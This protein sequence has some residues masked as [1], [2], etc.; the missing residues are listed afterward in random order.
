MRNRTKILF[1]L[2]VVVLVV[3]L[4]FYCYA[5]FFMWAYSRANRTPAREDFYL[6]D[7]EELHI[8]FK[9]NWTSEYSVL[10]KLK[11]KTT[12]KLESLVGAEPFSIDCRIFRDD[13]K[14][15][16]QEIASDVLNNNERPHIAPGDE[17]TYI[18]GENRFELKSGL[19]YELIA[20]VHGGSEALDDLR[21]VLLVYS[22]R[23]LPKGHWIPWFLG[24]H[25]ILWLLPGGLCLLVAAMYSYRSERK[26][27][28]KEES[29]RA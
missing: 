5:S 14:I 29:F 28:T 8:P 6:Q 21:A 12:E 15:S 13:G 17:V 16:L 10:L 25:R 7:G 2:G 11:A 19:A 20:E 1:A 23:G 9:P 27:R 22:G 26:Q 3:T 4:V 18:R 24:R